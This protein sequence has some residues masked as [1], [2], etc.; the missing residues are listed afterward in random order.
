MWVLYTLNVY[1][2][3]FVEDVQTR[4]TVTTTHHPEYSHH[5][6]V[7]N[8]L[9]PAYGG[10][11][12]V[13]GPYQQTCVPG[14]QPTYQ[15]AGKICKHLPESFTTLIINIQALPILKGSSDVTCTFTSCLN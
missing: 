8:N 14:P 11:P 2:S 6:P 7:A 4:T 1:K 5:Q 9:Q 15:E 3:S 13:T 12:I 10:H